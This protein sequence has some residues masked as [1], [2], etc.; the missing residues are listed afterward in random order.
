MGEEITG[1]QIKLL[2]QHATLLTRLSILSDAE[3]DTASLRALPAANSPLREL[4]LQ[5]CA[6]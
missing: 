6:L 5:G 3:V 2:G 4:W 1:Q